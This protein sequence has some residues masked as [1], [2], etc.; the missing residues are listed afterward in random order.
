MNVPTLLFEPIDIIALL[1]SVNPVSV[2]TLV[3][4]VC[5]AVPIVPKKVVADNEPLAIFAE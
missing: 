2:P 1:A 3:I 5:D 4:F